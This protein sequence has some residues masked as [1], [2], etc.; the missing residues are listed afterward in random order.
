MGANCKWQSLPD[1]GKDKYKEKAEEIKDCPLK[2][3][4]HKERREII[5]RMAKR[6]QSDVCARMC[7]CIVCYWFFSPCQANTAEELGFG[8]A[9]MYYIDGELVTVGTKKGKAYLTSH[10]AI[11]ATFQSHFLYGNYSNSNNII[12]VA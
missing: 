12:I 8:F 10:P 7:V 5:M 11:L 3:L 4:T 9:G 2:S 1:N 6:H